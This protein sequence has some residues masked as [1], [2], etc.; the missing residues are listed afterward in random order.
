M[1]DQ[2]PKARN[3]NVFMSFYLIVLSI[4]LNEFVVEHS[5]LIGL[6]VAAVFI[7]FFFV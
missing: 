1:T 5:I 7:P 4:R 6:S 3:F 2:P